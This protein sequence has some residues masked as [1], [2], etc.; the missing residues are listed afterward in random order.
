L[1]SDLLNIRQH[2][3]NYFAMALNHAQKLTGLS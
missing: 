1:N 3:N 2:G